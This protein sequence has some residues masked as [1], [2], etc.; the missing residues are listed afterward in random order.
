MLVVGLTGGIA[1]G[2]SAVTTMLRARGITVVDA[3]AVAHRL[4]EPGQAT[5]TA[6]WHTFGWPALDSHGYV[7]RRWLGRRVFLDPGELERLNRIMHPAVRDELRRE[8]DQARRAGMAVLVLDVPLLI[9]NGLST[10]VDQVW[11]VY[12]D[13]AE[14]ERRLM[15]RNGLTRDAAR[16]RMAAQMPI[17]QKRHFASV[18]LDNRGSLHDLER[19]VDAALRGLLRSS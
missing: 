16:R 10:E 17:D 3:D 15:A 14:Q 6:I 9:E 11:L 12:C 4:Q 19:Q 2:K 5:W 18:I 1:T 7:N 8:V 13:P